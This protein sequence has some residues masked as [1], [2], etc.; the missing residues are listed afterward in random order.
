MA[1]TLQIHNS[2]LVVF[3][4]TGVPLFESYEVTRLLGYKQAGSLRKQALASWKDQFQLDTHYVMVHDEDLLRLYEKEHQDAGNGALFPVKT[5]RGRLFFT[6]TGMSEVL[7]RTS[8]PAEEFR[9]ALIQDGYLKDVRE[10]G[11]LRDRTTPRSPPRET[12]IFEYEVIQKL[13]EQLERLDEPQLRGLAI[14]AAE[15]ALDRKLEE[16]RLGESVRHT[17]QGLKQAHPKPPPKPPPKPVILQE[18]GDTPVGP[19]LIQEDYYSMTFIG[20]LAGGYTAKTVGVAVDM[21]AARLGYTHDQIRNEKLPINQLQ[22][23]PDSS[24]GKKRQMARFTKEFS[25]R[26]LAELRSNPTL[27]PT[28]TPGIPTLSTLNPE[29]VAPRLNRGPFDEDAN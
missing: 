11:F 9:L 15:I 5:T 21:V 3:Q 7:R 12:R 28:L 10:S 1:T 19:I 23:R 24:T 25:N 20:T 2:N 22:M 18:D 13:I 6:S 14:T 29:A 8:K 27:E 17:F 26:V 4:A 16:I